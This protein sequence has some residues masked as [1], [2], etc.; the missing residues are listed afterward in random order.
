MPGINKGYNTSEAASSQGDDDISPEI[1]EKLLRKTSD[2]P[3]KDVED[4]VFPEPWP[5][6]PHIRHKNTKSKRGPRSIEDWTSEIRRVWDYLGDIENLSKSW[7][8]RLPQVQALSIS[9][10]E[11]GF[12]GRGRAL[13]ELMIKALMVARQFKTDE[14]THTMLNKYPEMSVKAIA[15]KYGVTREQFSRQYGSK[16]TSILTMAFQHVIGRKSKS[17]VYV[18]TDRSLPE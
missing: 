16:A 15:L 10:Y 5:P 2:G 14:R 3:M 12:L 17:R 4:V 13:R 6:F 9:K 8:A 7:L 11:G 18:S 1:I